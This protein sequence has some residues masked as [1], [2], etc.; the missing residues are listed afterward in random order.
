M[1]VGTRR[2]SKNSI[3]LRGENTARASTASGKGDF[4]AERSLIYLVT[5]FKEVMNMQ[6]VNCRGRVKTGGWG[7][8]FA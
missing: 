3:F 2:V 8:G 6:V 5:L 1:A 7:E 4:M